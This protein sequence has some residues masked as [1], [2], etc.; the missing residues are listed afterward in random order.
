MFTISVAEAYKLYLDGDG[1]LEFQ[2][3][4]IKNFWRAIV[5]V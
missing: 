2:D 3:F 5:E 1:K 4:Y